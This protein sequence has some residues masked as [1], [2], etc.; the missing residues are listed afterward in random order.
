[1]KRP[2][3]LITALAAGLA[4]AGCGQSD[5][6]AATTNADQVTLSTE[7]AQPA[8]T[9]AE[10]VT[11][12]VSLSYRERMALPQDAQVIAQLLDVSLADAPAVVLAEKHLSA[13]GQVPIDFT[14]A[15]DPSEVQTNHRYALR[16]E[17]RDAGGDLLW[18]TTE[19]HGVDL[20]VPQDDTLELRLTR[21]SEPAPQAAEAMPDEA[22]AGDIDA[23]AGD[24]EV[25]VG[26]S[27]SDANETV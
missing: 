2:L 22:E 26:D 19:H 20:T 16:G 27:D 23:E 11:L 18:T 7:D 9:P 14:L 10:P 6:V 4:L 25:E 21:I 12:S 5:E 24:S 3:F 1:M 8:A 15:Y 13:E 17:I